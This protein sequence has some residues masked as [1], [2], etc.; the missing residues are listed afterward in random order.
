MVD[1]TLYWKVIESEIE[2]WFCVGMLNSHAL[3]EAITPFNPKGAFGER[4]IHALPYRL[5][6]AFDPS[7]EEH[8]RIAELAR[9]IAELAGKAVAADPYLR[10]PS[11]ALTARRSRLRR[12]C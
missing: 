10:D 3:T 8:L 9:E 1:Q 11:R 12:I 7:N 5:I 6:P 2:A 4:H